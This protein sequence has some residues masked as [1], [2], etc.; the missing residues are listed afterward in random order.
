MSYSAEISRNNPGCFLFVVDQSGSMLDALPNG[1]SK[2][3]NV[4]DT[5]NRFLQN[6]VIKCSKSE[7]IHDYFYVGVIGYG[8]DNKVTSSFEGN[9]IGKEMI[10][11]SEIA[12]NPLEVQERDLNVNDST[13]N[14]VVQKVKF[15]IWFNPIADGSTPM[16]EAF[17]M[18]N[19]IIA[20]WLSQNPGCF[21]PIVVH[22]TDG[23]STDGDPSGEMR[24][25]M[26]Q[27]STD[28]GT[29][30]FNLHLSSGSSSKPIFFPDNN[31]TLPD[32]YA[33][34]LFNNSSLLTPS[35]LALAKEE[36]NINPSN[37]AR[38]F[39]FNGDINSIITALDIG[40]RPS[41]LK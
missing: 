15:P 27:T 25:L 41:N 21:P 19:K 36:Y 35:M 6:L 8:Q 40:T 16:K 32:Q 39:V 29:L 10:P 17:T 28:G 24:Q 1:K 14:S 38:G 13:G 20:N 12:Y 26:N 33:E 7:G 22:I 18:V 9:L 31:E 11:I 23:A 30:L 2:A 3:N 4:A 34:M 37:K 5:V